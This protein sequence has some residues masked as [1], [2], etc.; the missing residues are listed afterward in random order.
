MCIEKCLFHGKSTFFL[1]YPGA[2]G[3]GGTPPQAGHHRPTHT[4][5]ERQRWGRGDTTSPHM[6]F[7]EDAALL[8]EIQEE[9]G[10]RASMNVISGRLAR[11][12]LVAGAPIGDACKRPFPGA[13]A[14]DP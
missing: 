13:L 3:D 5:R 7:G 1:K 8:V 6:A 2:L 11:L 14:S 9:L 10:N 4:L 12:P